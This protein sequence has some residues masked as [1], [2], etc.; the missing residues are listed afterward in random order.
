VFA[1]LIILYAFDN[2]RYITASVGDHLEVTETEYS[3]L[4]VTIMLSAE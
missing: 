1:C 4:A 3:L 2:R